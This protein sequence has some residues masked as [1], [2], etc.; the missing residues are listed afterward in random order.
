MTTAPRTLVTGASRGIG[1]EVVRQLAGAGHHVLVTAR[2]LTDA[3]QVAS[4]IVGS[5]GT[6]EAG[7][8][9]IAADD[10]ESQL[11]AILGDAPLDVLVNNAAAFADW[12][13]I[14][15]TADLGAARQVLEV[16]V[17]GTWRIIQAALPALRRS[18]AAARIVNVGSGSGSHGE[19]QFG[20]HA[21]P[22]AASYAVSKAAVHALTAKLAVELRD[23]GI[24]VV[25]AEPGLTAT[26]PGMEDM[27]ARP[28]ADGAASIVQAVVGPVETGVLYRDGAE[29]AW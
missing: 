29:L 24:T 21:M 10:A 1:A 3:E 26:A 17:F 7:L 2:R 6:A 23:A 13:E 14:A 28:V 8:L 27:G 20:L 16:N 5:G 19:P 12:G 11:Q 22:V 4:E 9:D 25:A 18:P 15:S